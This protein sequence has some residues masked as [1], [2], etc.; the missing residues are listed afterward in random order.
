MTRARERAVELVRKLR[1]LEAADGVPAT[2]ARAAG[3]RA[4]RLAEEHG[5]SE[6]ECS[7]TGNAETPARAP[8]RERVERP[9]QELLH[10]SLASQ[11]RLRTAAGMEGAEELG[12][13]FPPGLLPQDPEVAQRRAMEAAAAGTSGGGGGRGAIWSACDASCDPPPL[14]PLLT[15]LGQ[16]LWG[17]S[18]ANHR[19]HNALLAEEIAKR[20]ASVTNPA[21]QVLVGSPA[22]CMGVALRLMAQKGDLVILQ[23][24]CAMAVE[25]LL[26][27]VGCRVLRWRPAEPSARHDVA[28]LTQLFRSGAPATLPR[29][30]VLSLPCPVT[31][32]LLTQAELENCAA[33]CRANGAALLAE[34]THACMPLNGHEALTP[35]TD[36]YDQGVSC[37]SLGGALGLDVLG[38]G[39]LASRNGSLLARGRDLVH[40]GSGGVSGPNALLALAALRNSHTLIRRSLATSEHNL[41]LLLRFADAQTDW[42]ACECAPD[43]GA[44]ALCRLTAPAVTGDAEEWCT[45]AARAAGVAFM[46][47]A[48]LVSRGGAS[49]PYEHLLRVGF[50]RESMEQT[51]AALSR[52][53]AT[54]GPSL[55]QLITVTSL[56][57][58]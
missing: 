50:G 38:I 36:L 10:A 39:W 2:E 48:P 9:A 31:G 51:L 34:E 58:A 30:L 41:A 6:A 57:P 18:L 37:A 55:G 32:R 54:L 52:A 4:A 1:A 13:G 26:A 20:Y 12:L 40:Y 11:G 42:F 33:L 47:S 25:A 3:A 19:A 22:E 46:P 43:A 23:W 8:D 14:A 29:L 27:N 24:P 21:Q 49:E 28:V 45:R 35:V 5:L 15:D 7:G 56:S 53:V 17:K 44:A 16:E